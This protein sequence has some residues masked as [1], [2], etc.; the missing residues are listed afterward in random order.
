LVRVAPLIKLVRTWRGFLAR[1][2][3]DEEICGLLPPLYCYSQIFRN[4]EI[5]VFD[6]A[7]VAEGVREG[8]GGFHAPSGAAI[9]HALVG[10]HAVAMG[11]G[12]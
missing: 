1:V 11:E 5:A 9:T 12:A 4:V 6:A 10:K 8:E 7:L 2:I 3:R